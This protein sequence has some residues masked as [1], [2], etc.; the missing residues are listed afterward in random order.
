MD[1]LAEGWEDVVED[2]FVLEVVGP[3]GKNKMITTTQQT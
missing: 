3:I 2:G 1:D